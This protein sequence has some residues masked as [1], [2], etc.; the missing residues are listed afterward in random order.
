MSSTSVAGHLGQLTLGDWVGKRVLV[1]E[2][3]LHYYEGHSWASV[4]QSVRIAR[5]L[6][7]SVLLATNAAGGIHPSLHP[8]SLVAIRDHVLW[9]LPTSWKHPGPGGL[10]S[11]RSTPY[12]SRLLQRLLDAACLEDIQLLPGVYASLTG[13]CYET[14]AEIR[15]LKAWGADAV[16][17]STAREV[18]LAAELGMSCAAVSCITNKAAG[19]S[20]GRLDHRDVLATAAAQ[21]ERVARLIERFL[22]AAG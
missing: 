10:G 7:A 17:M 12:C 21:T 11:R 14:P 8:G 2:G 6:G 16:G 15:A 18:E 19:L 22:Q 4:V 9:N 5:S 3:R 20:D 1:F 13:P